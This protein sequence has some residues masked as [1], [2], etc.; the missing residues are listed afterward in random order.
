MTE[1]KPMD[2][3]KPSVPRPLARA[4]WALAAVGVA[5][6]LAALS[7][8][9]GRKGLPAGWLWGFAWVWTLTLGALFFVA[10][11]HV[12]HAVWSVG[13]R[14]P[15]E[16]FAAAAGP[17]GLLVLPVLASAAWP[18]AFPLFEWAEAAHGHGPSLSPFKQL[19]LGTPFFLARGAAFAAVAALFAHRFVSLSLGQDGGV[20]GAE[21]TL[22]LRRASIGFMPL[23]AAVVTL[24]SFDW[25]MSLEPEW[26]SAVFGV[27]VFA[28]M[29]ASSLAAVTLLTLGLRRAGRLG[30]ADTATDDHLYSLGGLLFA[31]TCF[32][33]YIAFSQYMLT[34]YSN[35]PEEAAFFRH[36][37]RNGWGAVTVGLWIVRFG[38]PFLLLLPRRAKRDGR[39]LAAASAVVLAGQLI[40]LYWIIMPA[41]RRD[42]PVLGPAEAGPPLLMS[43]LLLLYAARFL[44]RHPAVPAGDPLI[45][46]C[47]RFRL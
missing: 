9:G 21:S 7:G 39:A 37:L 32:W 4:G 8:E 23:F 26:H 29:A 36:R 20:G 28:G 19:W 16:V 3:P 15:A 31:F 24:A 25:L 43:G 38:L 47:R 12:T 17:A 44:G 41:A 6:T 18:R 30:N 11:H 42:G 14:R 34:W 1:P 33:A 22:R 13:V 46:E 35:L 5:L 10:L 40:D 27:Y 2:G 45:G